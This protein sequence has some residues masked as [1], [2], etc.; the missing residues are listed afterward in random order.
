MK[1]RS[2]M[3]TLACVGAVGCAGSRM[4]VQSGAPRASAAPAAD[5]STSEAGGGSGKAPMFAGSGKTGVSASAMA[6]E[7]GNAVT[8]DE[9]EGPRAA[10]ERIAKL[11]A[12][13]AHRQGRLLAL[14]RDAVAQAEARAHER[15]IKRRMERQIV[16]KLRATLVAAGVKGSI[17]SGTRDGRA[18]VRIPSSALFFK[19]GTV[20]TQG[21]RKLLKRLAPV[22][23]SVRQRQFLVAGHVT[24]TMN[25]RRDASFQ[26]SSQR[27]MSVLRALV[28]A[29]V[30]GQQLA[31]VGY[32]AAGP[33]A[34]DNRGDAIEL[35][36]LGARGKRVAWR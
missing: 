28:A 30:Q 9:R 7:L 24:A 3:L 2:L 14:E 15:A 16:E 12:K 8:I 18:L 4:T 31:A 32:G 11:R 25:K 34:H 22:F 26:I 21:G 13:L 33:V 6:L 1:P 17:E 35:V 23:A 19:R 36:L 27:A 5:T 29:G 20:V 10:R